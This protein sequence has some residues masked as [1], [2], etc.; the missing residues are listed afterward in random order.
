MG[1]ISLRYCPDRRSGQGLR[2]SCRDTPNQFSSCRDRTRS[3]MPSSRGSRGVLGFF[4]PN[5]CRLSRWILLVMLSLR[6]L[7]SLCKRSS[8]HRYLIWSLPSQPPPA[9]RSTL[10]FLNVFYRIF[11]L[12]AANA[13]PSQL[14]KYRSGE[15]YQYARILV[16]P[17]CDAILASQA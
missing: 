9:D 14:L 11:G 15:S 17:F 10:T 7:H 16:T 3:W 6:A 5:L 4:A 8:R 2:R 13:L 1:E 12:P